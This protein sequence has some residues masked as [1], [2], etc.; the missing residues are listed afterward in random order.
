[1]RSGF[2]E[3]KIFS[4]RLW[5]LQP[6]GAFLRR[7]ARLEDRTERAAK[8]AGF[9]G[10][11]QIRTNGER[12]CRECKIEKKSSRSGLTTGRKKGKFIK[13]GARSPAP[14]YRA[15]ARKITMQKE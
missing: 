6:A 8:G 12:F 5:V 4:K 9:H 2:I 3:W 1:M 15:F 14:V 11:Q 7:P 13:D 10:R